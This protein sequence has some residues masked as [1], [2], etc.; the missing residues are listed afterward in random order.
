[1]HFGKVLV[2]GFILWPLVLADRY[3]FFE[4]LGASAAWQAWIYYIL[5]II[6]A[7]VISRRLGVINFVEA[8][9]SALIW[10]L[11]IL[12][13]DSFIVKSLNLLPDE[14][15]RSEHYWWSY[16]AILVAVFFLHKK[17]HIQVRKL[18]HE[19]H[20]GHGYH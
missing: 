8:I 10:L 2:L 4:L 17:R 5:L 1:M 9:F 14:V 11:M 13:L 12:L 7:R 18:L 20:H 15:F 3:V 19:K 16:V 6:F